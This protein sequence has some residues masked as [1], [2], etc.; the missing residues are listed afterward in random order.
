MANYYSGF[1]AHL[2]W[3]RL[4]VRV[5]AVSDKYHIS[6]TKAY[7]CWV[8][9]WFFW[10]H[11]MAWWKIVFK[12]L[13]KYYSFETFSRLFQNENK[14]VNSTFACVF[15]FKHDSIEVLEIIDEVDCKREKYAFAIIRCSGVL[16]GGHQKSVFTIRK[17]RETWFASLFWKHVSGMRKFPSLRNPEFATD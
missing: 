4:R 9:F 6:C 17:N 10:V 12:K 7:D 2:G 13:I 14:C 15:Q 16:G 3:N 5:P 1:G 8:L 11:N